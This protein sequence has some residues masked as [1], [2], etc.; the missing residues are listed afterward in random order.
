MTREE[1]LA[2]EPGRELDRL[3]QEH[4]FKWIP[5][6]EGRGDYTAIV[7]QKPGEQEPY[8]R[9]QRWEIAKERYSIIPY[10]E[11]NEMVHAVYG[12]KYW[13]S[14]ISAAWEV[15]DKLKIAIIP[16][17]PSAPKEL[18][19]YAEYENEPYVK[20]IHVFAETAPEAICKVALLAVLEEGEA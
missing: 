4:V 5:W 13:S 19:Y 8:M 12:D 10:S 3:I 15:V 11:I 6:Q 7:Y 1:I 16:Q 18:S 20:K 17:S 14:D 2:M 9:T